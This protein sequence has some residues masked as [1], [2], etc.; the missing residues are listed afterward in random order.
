MKV[1][2]GQVMY[3]VKVQREN[4]GTREQQQHPQQLTAAA[5]PQEHIYYAKGARS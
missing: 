3:E 4:D 2:G 1:Q 5:G